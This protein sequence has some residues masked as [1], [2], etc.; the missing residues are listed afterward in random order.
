MTKLCKV[1]LFFVLAGRRSVVLAT[2]HVPVPL[3]PGQP[4]CHSTLVKKF[5]P[6]ATGAGILGFLLAGALKD[7]FFY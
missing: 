7:L 1:D 4:H 3:V 5:L 6:V 2:E